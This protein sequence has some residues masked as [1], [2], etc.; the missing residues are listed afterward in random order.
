MEAFK[1]LQQPILNII[2][3]FLYRMAAL[4]LTPATNENIR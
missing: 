3:H 1:V 4:Q 2:M